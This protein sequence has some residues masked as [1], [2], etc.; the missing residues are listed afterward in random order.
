MHMSWS[1]ND[2]WLLFSITCFQRECCFLRAASLPSHTSTSIECI[3]DPVLRC[4]CQSHPGAILLFCCVSWAQKMPQSDRK[5]HSIEL[6]ACMFSMSDLFPRLVCIG[7]VLKY[8]IYSSPW[9]G[10]QLS[11]SSG[12]SWPA[13]LLRLW[14]CCH[15]LI[16]SSELLICMFCLR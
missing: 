5:S 3:C 6:L 9:A 4:L 7:E 11:P 12:T 8:Y 15:R 13:T 2:C 14:S 10:L 1:P 16:R